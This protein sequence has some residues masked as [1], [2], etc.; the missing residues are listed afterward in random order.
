MRLRNEIV[1]AEFTYAREGIDFL[2]TITPDDL[3]LRHRHGRLWNSYQRPKF[4]AVLAP[5]HSATALE[6]AYFLR[7]LTF[8]HTEHLWQKVGD[9]TTSHGAAARWRCSLDE[10]K[11][12]G[13]II[14]GMTLERPEVASI[15]GTH[16]AELLFTLN[17]DDSSLSSQSSL[18]SGRGSAG[19]ASDFRLGD[20]VVVYPYAPD[21]EPDVCRDVVFRAIIVGLKA[22]HIRVHLRAAEGNV[23]VFSETAHRPWAMEHDFMESSV[24]ALNRGLHSLLTAPQPRRDLL[25]LQRRPQVDDSLRPVL[26]HGDFNDLAQR[27]VQARDLFLIIGPPGTGK[28]SFGLMTAVRETLARDAHASLLLVAY[29]NRAVDEICSKLLADGIDFLRVGGDAATA[30]TSE[31][32]SHLLSTRVK[33]ARGIADVRRLLTMTRVL[34]ATTSAIS[35][36]PVLLITKHFDLCIVDEASQILEPQLMTLWSATNADGSTTI[37]RFLLIGDHKQLPAVVCQPSIVSRVYDAQLRAIGL[38]DCRNSLFHRLLHRYANDPTVCYL[39]RRQGRMHPDIADFPNRCFY[40]GQLTDAGLSHQLRVST[41]PRMTFIDVLTVEGEAAVIAEAVLRAYQA[42]G[43]SFDAATTVGVIV[44]YRKQIAAVRSCLQSFHISALADITIDTVERYQG[45]QRDTIIY[46][47]TV[48]QQEQLDFLRATS[49]EEDGITIDPK[50]NV[51]LTRAREYL[52]I[53]GNAA[54]LSQDPLFA[55]LIEHIKSYSSLT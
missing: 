25:L 6:R 34:V 51:A 26:D 13:S 47:F 28:T 53:I 31:M 29:T 40:G 14:I 49:F 52:I 42:A 8:V 5:I 17:S 24:S 33:A 1:A 48:S 12:E 3:N 32:Y 41:T 35:A 21:S 44:P 54:I 45:S 10:K 15:S 38:I 11:E 27:F 4:E 50:L 19:E 20:I 7:M 18:Y 37:E 36:Q 39:L 43:S 23:R 2:A 22:D 46:G 9:G 30:A 55:R 16:V